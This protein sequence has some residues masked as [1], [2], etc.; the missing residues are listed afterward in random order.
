MGLATP[1]FRSRGSTIPLSFYRRHDVVAIARELLGK[2]LCTCLP[3]TNAGGHG[4]PR[5][6]FTAGIIA[7]TEAYA[8]PEDRAS[9]AYG[10]R[11]TAR[12]S[13]MF[14]AG[15]AAYVYLCYG[16]HALFNVVTHEPGVPHAVLIRAIVPTHDIAT[17]LRRRGRKQLT[18]TLTTGP[19]TVAQALGITTD[20]T[21]ISLGGRQIWIEDAGI[22]VG[23]ADVVASPR[24]GVAYAGAHARRPWRFQCP[25][26]W[27]AGI[28][29]PPPPPVK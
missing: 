8:G 25:K 19:G 1:D 20:H 23:A 18:R 27:Q 10:N 24:V 3:S 15:G 7:E 6:V 4:R 2:R 22:T 28:A 17:M 9:H 12:T 13:I 26:L 14:R 11:R 29:A 21:G 16:M 5:A